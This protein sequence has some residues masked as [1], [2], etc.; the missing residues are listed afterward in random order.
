MEDV[1]YNRIE[2]RIFTPVFFKWRL[3][4]IIQAIL[5]AFS[6]LLGANVSAQSTIIATSGGLQVPSSF[7]AVFPVLPVVGQSVSGPVTMGPML[8]Y[9][10]IDFVRMLSRAVSTVVVELPSIS[11][12]VGEPVRIPIVVRKSAS[13]IPGVKVETV[14]L[15]FIYQCEIIDLYG[16][17]EES[18]NRD[19]C[20]A[21]LVVRLSQNPID[22]FWIDGLS[23]L[24]GKTSTP[25]SASYSLGYATRGRV[26]VIVENGELRQVGHCVTEGST[27]LVFSAVSISAV[28]VLSGSLIE[29]TLD[30]KSQHHG[31][32]VVYDLTG[33]EVHR[34]PVRLSRE[35]QVFEKIDA[36]QLTVGGYTVI[37]IH[38]SGISS[39]TVL[40]Y[41]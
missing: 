10:G 22:T 28:A 25:L 4:E 3:V 13:L 15:R 1:R 20:E 21:S 12:P 37:Y 36:S 16:V 38:E 5:L 33:N 6:A 31:E 14:E 35:G 30:S 41:K 18:R 29:V 17:H 24:C 32:L 9:V 26:E 34:R 8:S 39:T 7:G 11:I 40:V 27:R 2:A 23:K 19:E